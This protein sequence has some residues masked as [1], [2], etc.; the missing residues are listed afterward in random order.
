MRIKSYFASRVELAVERAQAELGEDAI[1]LSSRRTEGDAIEFGAYEVVF[2]SN[3]AEGEGGDP[4]E[5]DDTPD[6]EFLE[7]E[8]AAIGDVVPMWSGGKE[9]AHSEQPDHTLPADPI[10]PPRVIVFIGPGGA[11]K[12]SSLMKMAFI[13]SAVRNSRVRLVQMDGNRLAPREPLRTFSEILNVPFLLA[14]GIVSTDLLPADSSEY[15]LIDTP[16]FAPSDTKALECLANFL[17]DIP[18]HLTHLVLPAWWPPS[19]LGAVQSR[20]APFSP[21]HL[22]ITRA[23]EVSG[24]SVQSLAAA[25][26]LPIS[27]V[28]AGRHASAGFSNT[29]YLTQTPRIKAA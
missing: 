20:F 18:G 15:V 13:L 24:S 7:R 25:C 29:R 27:L 3:A 4:H 28:S 9:I 11:G 21:D 14:G 16:G 12:T 6:G 19:E 8:L 10:G 1:L 22:L 5:M 2:G 26:P 17:R 23:D